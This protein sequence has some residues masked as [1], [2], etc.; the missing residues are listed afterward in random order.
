MKKLISLFTIF[1]LIS[2]MLGFSLPAAAA[3][4]FKDVGNNYYARNEILSLVEKDVIKGF[5]DGTFR[6][7]KSVTRAEFATFVSRALNLPAAGSDFKDVP[8]NSSLYDGVSRAAKVGIIKGFADGTFRGGLGVT[9]EDMAV[10]LDRAM[11]YKGNYSK[12]STLSFQDSKNIGGYAVSSVKKMAA[13]GI[14]EDYKDSNKF[15][16]KKV[17]TRAETARFIYRTLSVF[18]T[19]KPNVLETDYR[20]MSLEQLNQVYGDKKAVV[21]LLRPTPHIEVLD[22]MKDYYE[23]LHSQ[24]WSS[25]MKDPNTHFKDWKEYATSR[26]SGWYRDYPHVEVIS[27]N[28]VAFKNTDLH[29]P[30]LKVSSA[31]EVMPSQ[32]AEKGKFLID[33]HVYMEDFVTYRNDSVKVNKLGGI[34]ERIDYPFP[35]GDEVIVNL[36]NVFRDAPGVNVAKGGLEL[37]YDGKKIVLTNGSDQAKVEEYT[38]KL[39]SK[40]TIKNGAAFGPVRAI[41]KEIGLDSR[42]VVNFKRFE[43]ANYPLERRDGRWQ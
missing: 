30:G 7:E 43:I 13:Y 12:T 21:R 31:Y 3:A 33:I 5:A 42:E 41:V 2:S 4:T 27:Y 14:M 25:Y 32:P 17:G 36:A 6:P 15:S 1:F 38:V 40:V 29:S 34:P 19:G 39:P 37:S 9:R 20:K 28:G 26:Y 11:T 23:R 24:M 10:M 22:D 35:K 18:E 16:G 8:K